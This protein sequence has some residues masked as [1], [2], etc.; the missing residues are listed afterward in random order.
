MTNP[1]STGSSREK[2]PQRNVSK[3][4]R[5]FLEN[6]RE[7]IDNLSWNR[8]ENSRDYRTSKIVQNYNQKSNPKP[9]IN[10]SHFSPCGLNVYLRLPKSIPNISLTSVRTQT[11]YGGGYCFFF[12]LFSPLPSQPIPITSWASIL[13]NFRKQQHNSSQITFI[14]TQMWDEKRGLKRR[15][16]FI[17]HQNSKF[18]QMRGIKKE[19]KSWQK[20]LLFRIV[21]F[22]KTTLFSASKFIDGYQFV[23]FFWNAKTCPREKKRKKISIF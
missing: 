21:G 12:S 16:K 1:L 9:G 20:S 2:T 8:L 15:K 22:E 17:S 4:R 11:D 6:R 23:F 5:W 19:S 3:T 10:T 18:E 7:I 13:M 14:P